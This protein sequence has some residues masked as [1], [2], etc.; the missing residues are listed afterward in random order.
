MPQNRPWRP[1]VVLIR[2]DLYTLTLAQGVSGRLRGSE[3]ILYKSCIINGLQEHPV[4][5]EPSRRAE[6]SRSA[7]QPDVK[8]S[9][10]KPLRGALESEEIRRR[11]FLVDSRETDGKQWIFRN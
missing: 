4:N 5:S 9:R 1:Q 11:G 2:L 10:A 7:P 3:E 6:E 8:Q